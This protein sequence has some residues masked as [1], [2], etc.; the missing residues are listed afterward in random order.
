[1]RLFIAICVCR[2]LYFIGRLIGKGTSKPGDIA[3]IICPKVLNRLKFSG[4]V[5]CITGTNGKTTTSNM[6]TH[7]LRENGFSVINNSFGSNMLGGITT[8]LLTNC[9]FGGEVKADFSVL[10]I[11]ERWLRFFVKEVTPDYV[12]LTN[13][14]RD[15]IV[16]NCCP[17][18]VL[19]K[20]KLGVTPGTTY[21]LNA[22]DP[23]SQQVSW[24]IDNPI[25]WFALGEN[26]RSTRECRSG[27]NDAK[28]CPKCMHNL[29]YNYY[30]Y[31][32]VGDFR[33]ENCGFECPKADYIGTDMNFE[34]ASLNINGKPVKLTFDATYFMFN[35]VAATALCC[36]ASGI[37][38]EKALAA[39]ETFDIGVIKRY[40]EIKVLGRKCQ[41][42]LTKQNPAS[43][44]QSVDFVADK[45]APRTLIIISNNM[46]HTERKDVLFMYDVAYENLKEV[47]HIVIVGK[48]RYDMAVRLKLADIDMERV[49]IC[50]REEDLRSCLEKTE[51][52]IYVMTSSVFSNEDKVLEELKKL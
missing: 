18:I 3:R 12:L 20:I 30:H 8:S 22:N 24:G 15:Q 50:D 51:G 1:M 5:I 2:V 6:V 31:N 41:L 25:V 9:T 14:L 46:F 52:N 10:E 17:E 32:H 36:S 48:R 45:E 42:I 23:V 37:S 11:D 19:E 49:Q 26:E 7:I 35:A 47:E 38:T 43:I 39:A 44:D 40:E 13:L 28:V 16:R 4:K 29:S 21:I 33:C 34:E 27:T